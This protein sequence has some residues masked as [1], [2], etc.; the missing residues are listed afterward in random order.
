MT[1]VLFI[2]LLAASVAFFARTVWLF[3]R[4]LA[5]GTADPRPRLDQLP[6]RLADVGIYFSGQKKV[7]EGDFAE[8]AR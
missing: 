4:G 3:G 2:L 8:R 6:Q 7:A 5:Q 1:Q